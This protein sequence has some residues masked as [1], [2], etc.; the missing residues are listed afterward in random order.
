[1][2]VPATELQAAFERCR[3]MDGPINARLASYSA[4]LK[5]INPDF[6]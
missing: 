1:M 5:A 3:D 2:P 4:S 6:A